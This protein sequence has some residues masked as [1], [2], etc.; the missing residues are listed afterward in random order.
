MARVFKFG[1]LISSLVFIEKNIQ[2][3]ICI[4]RGVDCRRIVL[5]KYH[6]KIPVFRDVNRVDWCV[7]TNVLKDTAASIVRILQGSIPIYMISYPTR[8]ESL[9]TPL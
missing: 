4:I 2:Y 8:L 6:I 9:S 5:C 3:K 1:C 7:G